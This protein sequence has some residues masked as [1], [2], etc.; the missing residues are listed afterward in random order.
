[1]DPSALLNHMKDNQQLQAYVV[2]TS[3]LDS[4]TIQA[5]RKILTAANISQASI[6]SFLMTAQEFSKQLGPI[7]KEF[8]KVSIE[9]LI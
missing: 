8:E 5:A 7:A 3:S 1:M 4:D 9:Q 6:D 2:D